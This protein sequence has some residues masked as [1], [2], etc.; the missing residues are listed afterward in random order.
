MV[1][2][3]VGHERHGFDYNDAELVA[4]QLEHFRTIV[5]D[6]KGHP[7]LLLWG[8]GNEVNLTYGNKKVWDAI[9]GIAKMIHEEDG[10]HPTVAV[11]SGINRV[12]INCIKNQCP[13]I[14]IVGI[15]AYGNVA[16]V[17][18]KINEYAWEKPY[19]LTEWGPTGH[20]ESPKTSWGAPIEPTSTEKAA[21]C[22]VRYETVV[23]K[24]PEKCLGSYVFMWGN[25]QEMTATWYSTLIETGEETELV[26]VMYY[27]WKGQYPPNRTPKVGKLMMDGKEAKD[28]ISIIRKQGYVA[29]ISGTD[30]D[31]DSLH[32]EWEIMHEATDLKIGGDQE[33]T[34]WKL[35]KTYKTGSSGN[36]NFVAP[37]RK[38]NYRLFVYLYDG[39]NHVATA[40]IPF[41]VKGE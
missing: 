27:E 1:G 17:P 28:N 32:Y 41:N 9:Q 2:L 36:L 31:K 7:A 39:H 4:R 26:E 37:R 14:D 22:K 3:W 8:V 5:S 33:D 15:N 24:D 23:M 29:N 10:N 18:G 25:K 12:D 19:I 20:W 35:F 6:L 40:N 11:I 16:T 34:P 38:G 21:I 30:A 13:D